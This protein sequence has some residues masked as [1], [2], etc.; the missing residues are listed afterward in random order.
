MQQLLQHLIIGKKSKSH[1][2][3]TCYNLRND[4]VRLRHVGTHTCRYNSLVKVDGSDEAFFAVGN[5]VVKCSLR[6]PEATRTEREIFRDA[7]V[8]VVKQSSHV[9]DSDLVCISY[10]AHVVVLSS[11]LEIKKEFGGLVGRFRYIRQCCMNGD[12]ICF[13]SETAHLD[14]KHEAPTEFNQLVICQIQDN[15]LAVLHVL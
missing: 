11:E 9:P 6:D 10:D 5:R 13:I 4:L 2:S 15:V 7:A 3:G 12:I 1:E 8:M 14:S